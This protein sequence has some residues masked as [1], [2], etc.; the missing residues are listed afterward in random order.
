MDTRRHRIALAQT[1]TTEDV[2]ENVRVAH[3][4]VAQAA[5]SGAELL[6]FPEVFVYLG[7]RQGKLATAQAVDG[8]V[9][10]G[11]RE[12]AARHGI[13][14]LLGSFHERIESDPQRVHNTSVLL[15]RDGA[16]LA[17]YRKLKLFDVDLPDVRI[18][19]S[20]TVAPGREP[21]P[22]VDTRIGRLGLTICFD[23]RFSSLYDD[24]RARGAEIVFVPSNFTVPT[25]RAHWEI[26]LRA[27]AI[28]GQY[29]VV[30]PAQVGQ[31]NPR[32]SSYGHSMVVDP[33]GR[34]EAVNEGGP[35]LLY[36]EVDLDRVYE[37]R[38]RLPMGAVGEA[39]S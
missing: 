13:M 39:T 38:A 28:E 6:A 20:D 27:R 7:R 10:D 34:V 25:G 1:T 35:G 29:Y 4:L 32:Y 14:L 24:L 12:L 22:V 30:A 5:Q 18:R 36:A 31:H 8:P 16:L 2:E 23:L 37:V 19:E 3:E 21:P 26:L 15:D 33:W 9:V 17:S 11:F